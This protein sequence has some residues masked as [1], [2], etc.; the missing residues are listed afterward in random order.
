MNIRHTITS[1]SPV[2]VAAVVLAL[3]GL[4]TTAGASDRG[5]HRSPTFVVHPGESI[6]AA[7]DDAP[8]GSTVVINEGSYRENLLIDHAVTVRGRGAVLLQPPAVQTPNTCTE[9][10]RFEEPGQPKPT[11]AMCIVGELGP[12]DDMGVATVVTPLAGVTVSKI[13]VRGFTE[14]IVALGTEGLVVEH[15]EVDQHTDAGINIVRSTNAKVKNSYLHDNVDFAIKVSIGNGITLEGN[16]IIDTRDSNGQGL[17]V[18][19]YRNVVIRGNEVAG[20]CTGIMVVDVVHPGAMRNVRVY[21][22][23]V[24][25]NSRYCPGEGIPSASGNG[26]VLGGVTNAVVFDNEVSHNVAST[27]PATG[28]PADLAFGGIGLFDTTAF[29]GS[30]PSHNRVT[31]NEAT[32]N[33]P[34]DV[35]YDGSGTNVVISENDCNTSNVPGAC[36]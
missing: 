13:H 31:D 9:S 7:I 21:A 19:Q 32:D 3:I 33:Q 28:A 35:F 11:W 18:S 4:A 36:S 14:G 25:D 8:P 30:A 22:N 6:Q 34:N 26:I 1:A 24:H 16:R 15:V 5:S 23:D 2:A 17:N 29:G 10:G 27:D 12:L 20:N